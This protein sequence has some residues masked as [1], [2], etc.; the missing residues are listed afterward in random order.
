MY[1]KT[2][3][4]P[5]QESVSTDL[6][7]LRDLCVQFIEAL[8]L[9]SGF[10][11]SSAEAAERAFTGEEERFVYSRYGNPSVATF[12]ERLRLLEGTEAWVL[13]E[14]QQPV[15]DG[16]PGEL[17]LGGVGL[18]RAY[19]RLEDET[20]QRFVPHPFSPSAGA[21]LYRTGDLVRRRADGNLEFLERIDDQIKLRGWRIEPKEIERAILTHPAVGEA[22]VVLRDDAPG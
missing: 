12:Q 14:H 18:G 11:Y 4:S 22:A 6:S 16:A 8:F 15:P 5:F 7:L 2:E 13:D 3:P 9:T 17:Y 20:K 1:G 21:R 10:V 19:H